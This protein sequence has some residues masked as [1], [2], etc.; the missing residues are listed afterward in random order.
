MLYITIFIYLFLCEP[1]PK[2][3]KA[4]LEKVHTGL[5]GEIVGSIPTWNT[6]FSGVVVAHPIMTVC[7]HT[8]NF[9]AH[10]TL[11][12]MGYYYTV[13]AATSCAFFVFM[14]SR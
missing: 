14:Q 4:I 9:L 5:N 6:N 12:W 3:N 10:Q 7:D 8:E 11:V 13:A 1:Q 2:L